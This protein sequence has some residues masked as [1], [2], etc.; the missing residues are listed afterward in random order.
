M[1]ENP[2]QPNDYRQ[3]EATLLEGVEKVSESIKTESLGILYR[4][5]LLDEDCPEL[6]DIDLTVI[7][8]KSEEYPERKTIDTKNGRVFVD[9]LWVP[10]S[11][12]LDSH[13]AASYKILPHL[14]LE[15]EN[16]WVKSNTIKSIIDNIKIRSYEIAIWQKRIY[17]QM[18]FGNAALKEA[19]NNLD[20]PPAALFFLQTAHSYFLMG[21]ADC[22][23]HS[24]MS[25]LTKPITKVRYMDADKDD[26][27]EQIIK[28]NL[29]LEV[30]PNASLDE[31]KKVYEMVNERCHSQSPKSVTKRTLGH[32]LYTL[33]SLEFEYRHMVIE[34]LITKGDYM[35]ANFYLRFWAYSLSRCPVVLEEANKGNNPSFYVPFRPFRESINNYCP[36]ILDPMIVIFGNTTLD[37]VRESIKGTIKFKQLVTGKVEDRGISLKEI[38][39]S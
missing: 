2:T 16:V 32:Y 24:T 6:S 28:T 14:L 3:L 8:D 30:E 9:L 39:H 31:L 19:S 20:F 21:L 23:R 10:I 22:L 33:S 15:S 26:K 11:Q 18:I 5:P 38:H 36:E 35:N 34:S 4:K 1:N 13:T 37:E 12:M 17:N 29:S 7:Y 27:L 25:I